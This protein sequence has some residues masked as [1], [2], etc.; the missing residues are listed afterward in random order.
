MKQKEKIDY[1]VTTLTEQQLEI[2][3]LRQRNKL[4]MQMLKVFTDEL[5]RIQN[6]IDNLKSVEP[7]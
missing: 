7:K 5:I 4:F 1:L 6:E 2:I 3:E